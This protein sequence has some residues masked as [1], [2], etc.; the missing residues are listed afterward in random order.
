MSAR[1]AAESE[2]MDRGMTI[3]QI[4]AAEL[5]KLVSPA[6]NCGVKQPAYLFSGAAKVKIAPRPQVIHP[7]SK[8]K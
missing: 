6:L 7:V 4:K 1:E 3:Y 8:V 5:L 2:H